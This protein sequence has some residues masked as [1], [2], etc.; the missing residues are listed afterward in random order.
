MRPT[1]PWFPNQIKAPTKKEN[2]RPLSLRNMDAEILNKTLA[3]WI[4]QYIKRII[5]HYQLGFIPG[6][7][8]HKSINM[9]HHINKRKD[10]S[11]MIFSIDGEKAL[12]KI[13]HPFLIKN[14]QQR[15]IEGMYFIIMKAKTEDIHLISSSIGKNWEL[16]LYSRE[17]DRDVQAQHDYLTEYWKS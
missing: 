15:R 4:Q 7:S 2:W 6:F 3:N 9:M 1:L 14:L 12:D 10:K 16:F 17:Q 11:H 13:Q 8:I 5:H